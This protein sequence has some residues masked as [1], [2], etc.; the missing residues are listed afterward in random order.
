[1][2][3]SQSLLVLKQFFPYGRFDQRKLGFQAGSLLVH[4]LR[5]SI[6]PLGQFAGNRPDCLL[7]QL[8]L[9]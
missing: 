4:S 9:A 7:K 3:Q 2:Y 8:L 5:N 1:M 6:Q